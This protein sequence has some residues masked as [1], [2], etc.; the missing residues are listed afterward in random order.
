MLCKESAAA[1]P[2]FL[3][4][5]DAVAGKRFDWRRTAALVASVGV[6]FGARYACYGG[7][8]DVAIAMAN[9]PL[10]GEGIGVRALTVLHLGALAAR[11]IV[12][13]LQLVADYSWA[14]IMPDRGA[15][16]DVV[17]GAVG[18]IAASAAAWLFRKRN[19]EVAIGLTLFVVGFAAIS[20][21]AAPLPAI[22]AER[23][24]Y[25]PAAG[26]VVAAAGALARLRPPLLGAALALVVGG[27]LVRAELRAGDWTDDRALFGAAV[28]DEPRS[29]RSWTNYG[30][31]LLDA[32]QDGDAAQAFVN[33]GQL[34]P[35][36]AVPH[37]YAGIAMARL[38]ADVSAERE[39]REAYRLDPEL[40]PAV[41][42]LSAFLVRHGRPDEA[43]EILRPYVA[44]HP[45]ATA[46]RGLLEEIERKN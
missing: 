33:A 26:L 20:N 19:P 25:L 41:F 22:F 31:A 40:Q 24:L 7:P 14:A 36:W 44:R 23:L 12:A 35:E 45:E 30:M 43:A 11:T 34:Y 27:N 29:A 37:S 28:A 3:I 16:F 13:P 4:L 21:L 6:Y 8:G 15:S 46:P 17:L 9:N 2:V 39:F 18:L 10:L 1:V 38:G 5:A 42:N 32:H